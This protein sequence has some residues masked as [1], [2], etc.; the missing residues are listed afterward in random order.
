MET[1]KATRQMDINDEK[2]REIYFRA[3]SYLSDY[4]VQTDTTS[5]D[6]KSYNFVF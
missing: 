3:C 1:I 6:G 5:I 4:Y 2:V